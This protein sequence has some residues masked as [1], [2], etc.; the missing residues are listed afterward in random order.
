[1][2]KASCLLASER[3]A[4][5][6]FVV[7]S[8]SKRRAMVRVKTGQLGLVANGAKRSGVGRRRP[9][10][11]FCPPVSAAGG[12]RATLHHTASLLMSCGFPSLYCPP[13]ATSLDAV[14]K[15]WREGWLLRTAMRR[16]YSA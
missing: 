4:Y 1:M 10:I 3:G 12:W 14:T 7:A 2:E 15:S 16:S 5:E 13:R 11:G 8:V 9:G 6:T